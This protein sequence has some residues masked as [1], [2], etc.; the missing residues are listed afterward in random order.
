MVIIMV[1]RHTSPVPHHCDHDHLVPAKMLHARW[2]TKGICDE[3]MHASMFIV[4]L[5]LKFQGE[6][7][8]AFGGD[9]G[10]F[11]AALRL[12]LRDTYKMEASFDD[13]STDCVIEWS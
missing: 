4:G 10:D 6:F 2:G 1:H 12:Y 8:E 3:N 5:P 13:G 7:K 11:A 9:I